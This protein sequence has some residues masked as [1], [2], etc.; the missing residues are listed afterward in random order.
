MAKIL[1]KDVCLIVVSQR[2]I[3]SKLLLRRAQGQMLEVG[4]EI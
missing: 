1:S 3:V 4:K 2:T